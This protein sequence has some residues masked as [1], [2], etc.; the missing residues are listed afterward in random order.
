MERVCSVRAIVDH[1]VTRDFMADSGTEGELLP[2]V[3][4][5]VMLPNQTCKT[6]KIE[7]RQQTKEVLNIILE[8]LQVN[9]KYADHFGLFEA[10]ENN[11]G[12]INY[13]YTM[14]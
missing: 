11:F 13:Y 5:K 4:L 6:V 3:D 10:V 12:K 9:S 2:E 7:R 8:S 1:P 14:A